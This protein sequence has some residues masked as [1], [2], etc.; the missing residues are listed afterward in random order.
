MYFFTIYANEVYSRFVLNLLNFL[1]FFNPYYKFVKIFALVI[2]VQFSIYL[3]QFVS[4]ALATEQ[5]CLG[6]VLKSVII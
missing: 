4:T 1:I 6:I 3:S 2:S 5:G